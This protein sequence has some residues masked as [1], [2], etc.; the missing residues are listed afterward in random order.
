VTSDSEVLHRAPVSC[1]ASLADRDG[2]AHYLRMHPPDPI[3][4]L[5]S[6]LAGRYVVESELGEGGTATVYLARDV[7]HDRMVAL[8]VLKPDVAAALGERRFLAEIRT[9]ANL[10][11]PAILPLHDSGAAGELLF[12]VMPYVRG[13]TL[14]DRIR[15]DGP[16]PVDEVA[17]I[18][19]E[20]AEGLA[21]A[22]G[23][24]VVHRDLKPGNILLSEGR[25]VLADFG[26]ARAPGQEASERL[27]DTG[28]VGGTVRYM[29]P[30]QI[31]GD[32]ELDGRSD[33]YSLACVVYEMLV[34]QPPFPGRTAWAV[35]ASQMS[36]D[37]T[38]PST[39]RP[40]VSWGADRIIARALETEPEDRF[41]DT[42][43]FARSLAQ[44]LSRPGVGGR[45]AGRRQR[46]GAVA[47]GAAALA[48]TGFGLWSVR[49]SSAQLD[50]D[51]VIVFPLIDQRVERVDQSV[52]EQVAIMVGNALE[53][54][55][56][57]RWIDGWDWLDPSVR[58]DMESW[59]IRLGVDIARDRGA[60]HVIDG[61][62]MTKED[63]VSVVL[64]LHD[65]RSGDLVQTSL[66][67]GLSNDLLAL[68]T[69][70]LVSLL[71]NLIDTGR[72]VAT[73]ALGDFDPEA[74]AAWLNGERE[75]RES[76]FGP[77]LESFQRAI[78]SD[79]TMAVAAIRGAQ[80]ARWTLQNSR[81]ASL[82]ELA[83]QH[84]ESLSPRQRALARSTRSYYRGEAAEAERVLLDVTLQY[85]EW[86]DA[87]M[88][89]G[90]VYYHLLPS[91]GSSVARAEDAFRRARQNDP[92]FTPPLL[93]L[94]EFAFRRGDTAAGDS[95]REALQREGE[96]T[97]FT[98]QLELMSR[99]VRSGTDESSW[100]TAARAEDGL[101][102]LYVGVNLGAGAANPACALG[103]F[104]TMAEWS[105]QLEDGDRRK[106]PMQW[107]TLL[108]L[109]S[110]YLALGQEA[111]ARELIAS[112]EQ[113][114]NPRSYLRVVDAVGKSFAPGGAGGGL[115]DDAVDAVRSLQRLTEPSATALWSI[116]AWNA[117]HGSPETVR[118]VA[119]EA[120]DRSVTATPDS[121]SIYALLA[122][123]LDAWSA[124]AVADT[125]EA[126]ARFGALV[127]VSRPNDLQWTLWEHLAAE[128]LALASLLVATGDFED[129]I[130]VAAAFEHPQPV[131]YVAFVPE[132]LRL[133]IEATD[134]LGDAASAA[135][136]RRRLDR[137]RR[138]R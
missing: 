57:L 119:D 117:L 127:P 138:A 123:A 67:T 115:F 95:L 106:I 124:L 136:A 81:A 62:I 9:T 129:A 6:A 59:S 40:D 25:A 41:E 8:K 121:V 36:R 61:R 104:H 43:E 79:S 27:T 53:H 109:Q 21:Y 13:A 90:E 44:E 15:R 63:S 14:R 3:T 7:R 130:Q 126:I 49:P 133:R 10:Q 108:G 107:S 17:R 116:G 102:V 65:A 84:E 74:V 39:L 125:T 50:L 11:H 69:R 94:A 91:V 30:E 23:L 4:R 97:V 80:A 89:L 37:L 28:G 87:W 131:L 120:R 35:I 34:G 128:R 46:L 33:Q 47:L 70:A 78:E 42:R 134:R 32:R 68:G 52:G 96:A 2:D 112:A 55:R 38:S 98:T 132:S 118:Q 18:T 26:L 12:Y 137:L 113:F 19:S 72:P 60:R 54:S 110:L 22:H 83:L 1:G 100:A 45:K 76:R 75:Y 135:E 29:S 111:E 64:R 103:A 92:G 24:G 16:M 88:A 93:H 82:I 71:P 99:C 56:P 86:S 5:N 105:A 58:G 51:Q 77:A 85:P 48:A 20:L 31:R 101:A 73:Q 66:Q 122:D 114:Q